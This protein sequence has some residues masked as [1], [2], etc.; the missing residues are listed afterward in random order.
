MRRRL[1]YALDMSSALA[2]IHQQGFVHLDVKPA[3]VLIT[4]PDD[5]CKLGDFGCSQPLDCRHPVSG[6]VGEHVMAV[7]PTLRSEL[8]GTFAYRSP[9]LFRG[10]P[11]TAKADVYALGIVLWQLVGTCALVHS[12]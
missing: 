9:E 3:N 10:K 1:R 2:Y 8:M 5:R 6:V 12:H 11:A 7:C 4:L